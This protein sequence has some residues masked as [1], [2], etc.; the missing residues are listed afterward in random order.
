M[1]VLYGIPACDTVKRA[2]HWL[3]E[4]GIAYHFHDY[5]KAGVPEAMLDQWLQ[6]FGWETVINRRGTSWR[7][8]PPEERQAMDAPRARAAALAKPS[9]IKRPILATDRDT[10]VGFDATLWQEKLA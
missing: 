7:M 9:L 4:H 8:L 10:L 2:R 1:I 5:K 6:A 3:A